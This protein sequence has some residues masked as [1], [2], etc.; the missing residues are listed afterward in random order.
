MEKKQKP[1]SEEQKLLQKFE[2]KLKIE[3]IIKSLLIGFVCGFALCI[4]ISIISFIAEYNTIW[5]SVGVLAFGTVGFA[6]MS[7]V[8]YYKTSLKKTASRVDGVGLEERMITMLEF[9]DRNDAL[10]VRQREDAKEALSKVEPKHVKVPFPKFAVIAVVV[11]A[12][13]AV[14]MMVTSTVNAV[15]AEEAAKRPTVGQPIEESEEDRIIRELIEAIRK[16]INDADVRLSLKR[17]LHDL[18]DDLEK[19]LKPT[20]STEVKIAKISETAQEIH[21][22]LQN[23]LSRLVIARELKKHDTTYEIGVAIESG[24]MDKIEAAFMKM[25][26]SIAPLVGEQKYDQLI[27]TAM[28]ILTALEDAGYRE[29]KQKMF[30]ARAISQPDND[31]LAKALEELAEAM[32]AAVPPPEE[33]DGD[34]DKISDEVNKKLEDAIQDALGAIQ[35]ALDDQKEIESTD[36]DIMDK[37][38]DALEQLGHGSSSSDDDEKDPDEEDKKKD[39]D[40]S[41]VGPATPNE[42]GDLIYDSV[43]DGRTRSE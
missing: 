11:A 3:A 37:V 10:A 41:D 38:E 18:V 32:L 9:A 6:V 1:V 35:D 20:D 28:D 4:P 29:P 14:T 23:E 39:E 30:S 8:K 5:I 19:S 26:D 17:T 7:Y 42:D 13:I 34:E 21:R 36:K 24:E 40:S 22:I 16:E 27:K 15:R 31:K 12:A 43:I 2:R 33:Q 25:Y